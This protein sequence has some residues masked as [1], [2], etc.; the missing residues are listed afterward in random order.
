MYLIDSNL[1]IYSS[2]SKFAYLRPLLVQADASISE[3]SCLE[4]LGYHQLND[5]D[6][7]YFKSLFALM[8]IRVIDSYTIAKAI[9]L[10]QIRRM[11]VGDAIIAATAM[12]NGLDLYTHNVQDFRWIEGIKVIDPILHS[13]NS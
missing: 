8:P 10:R 6:E 9:Q 1:L 5:K 12:V 4:T 11:S 2:Q 13:E 3:I 7:R